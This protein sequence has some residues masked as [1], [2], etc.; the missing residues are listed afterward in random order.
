MPALEQSA[1]S[2]WRPRRVETHHP[3][4]CTTSIDPSPQPLTGIVPCLYSEPC[5]SGCSIVRPQLIVQ[6]LML[7][8]R[9]ASKQKPPWR[10]QSRHG[11]SHRDTS[12]SP[13]R[14]AWRLRDKAA[15]TAR[16]R[17]A[18]RASSGAGGQAPFP[19]PDRSRQSRRAGRH[20]TSPTAYRHRSQAYPPRSS[21]RAIHRRT[22]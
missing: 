11:H 7:G 17:Q 1:R 13:C 22:P 5:C 10:R 16:M 20:G 4:R 3:S 21:H 18:R 14:R 12:G 19:A 15:V 8:C 9:P 6:T 2:S